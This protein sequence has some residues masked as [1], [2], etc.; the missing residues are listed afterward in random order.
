MTL[1][2]PLQE[3]IPSR[4]PDGDARTPRSTGD[5][6]L[7]QLW[8]SE[9]G[10]RTQIAYRRDSDA[11]REFA[12]KRLADVRPIDVMRWRQ[13][14]TGSPNYVARR[15]SAVRSLFAFGTSIGIIAV[16]PTL[17]IK[18]PRGTSSFAA[19]TLTTQQV[20]SIIGAA[21][22]RKRDYLILR[23]LYASGMRVS[24]ICDVRVDDVVDEGA[25]LRI[26]VRGKGDKVR[27]VRLD[28]NSA[29]LLRRQLRTKQS[30]QMLFESGARHI[31]TSTVWRIVRRAA[32]EA[33]VQAPV[34]P[35][36]FRHAH[37]SHALARGCDL[38]TVRDSLGHSSL[39]VTSVYAHAM[40]QRSP[41]DFIADVSRRHLR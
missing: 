21:R 29:D 8:L 1:H 40:S 7:V 23:V 26:M 19:R 35:H 28:R 11:F 12:S 27:V 3:N 16:N 36:W 18:R 4:A 34:S 15:V 6:E 38:V 17:T 33:G 2:R 10:P 24:E 14:I 37:A 5:D 22:S 25:T 30:G 13:T 41:A 9:L 39:A 20:R 31:S 32:T